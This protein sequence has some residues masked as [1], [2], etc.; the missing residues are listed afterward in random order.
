MDGD[1][2]GELIVDSVGGF[3]WHALSKAARISI[4]NRIDFMVDK[5]RTYL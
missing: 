4:K 5:L 1:T 2:L 3:D